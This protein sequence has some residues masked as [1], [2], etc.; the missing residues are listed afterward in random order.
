MRLA[1]SMLP[2]HRLAAL[3]TVPKPLLQRRHQTGGERLAFPRMR[4]PRHGQN[5]RL[6]RT[7]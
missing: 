4:R 6:A 2:E 1:R 5:F 3:E 7:P